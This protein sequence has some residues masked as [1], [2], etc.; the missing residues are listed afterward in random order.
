MRRMGC[1]KRAV[2]CVLATVMVIGTMAGCGKKDDSYKVKL[3][4]GVEKADIYVEPI[5]GLPSDFIKGMDVSSVIAEEAAGVKYYD[6]DGKEQDLFKI[7]ADSGVNYIRVRVWNDPYDSKG[8]GYGGGNNDVAKAVEI[9]QRAA[10]Y[11]MKL[12]VDFHYSDFWA[13]PKKQQSPKAWAHIT[14]ADK[15]EAM[16]KFTTESLT[17]IRDGGADIGMVQIGNEINNGISGETE[18]ERICALL[19]QASKAIRDFSKDI[20][21]AVHYTNVD[22]QKG[23]LKRAQMLS[24][25]NVDYD[26]FGVSY[27]TYWHGTFDNMKSTLTAVTEKYGKKT[28]IMETSYAYTLEDGDMYGN[29]VGEGDLIPEYGA[30]VQSQAT[31]IR[32]VMAAA[33]E[34][35]ALGI[36]Y[37]EGAWVPVGS[38]YES[39]K[40]KWEEFGTGWASSYASKYDPKDAGLYYGG[41]SWD[42]QAFFDANGKVLPSLDVFKY[43][44]YGTECEQAIDY[45]LN[46]VVSVNVDEEI[47]MPDKFAVVF[48]NRAENDGVKVTWD[49]AQVAAIDTSVMAEHTVNG[50]LEDGTKVTCKVKVAELNYLLNPSFEENKLSMWNVTY[51]GENNPTDY[52]TKSSDARTGDV[53]FHFYSTED[54]CFSIEQTVAGLNAGNYTFTLSMQGGDIKAG[55]LI[56]IYAIANGQRYES[57]PVTLDG[58]VNWKEPKIENIA[59][60]GGAVT[61]GAYVKAVAKGWGTMDDFFLYKQK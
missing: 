26:V 43:V 52:Q 61:I 42:N 41:C 51:D 5:E 15:Q 50:T 39:N 13:D 10:K 14:F 1:I 28:C 19:T 59:V 33:N 3:P 6:K 16:Y 53:S 4:T 44:N 2:A 22:D 12:L 55:S 56:Y 49:A 8:N 31:C 23:I 37:W 46:C 34:V 25:N 11:G 9:G 60:S 57:D 24:D 27:Y 35:G 45:L 36:F 20:Q 54:F 30:T 29:S 58:W 7:L 18:D 17:A 38:D 32:D 47:V 40:L 21:I 48:N